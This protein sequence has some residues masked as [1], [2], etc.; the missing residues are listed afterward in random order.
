[1]KC[2]SFALAV[3][4]A[5]ATCRAMTAT[6]APY[7]R[8][9]PGSKESVTFDPQAIWLENDQL[10]LAIITCPPHAGQVFRLLYKPMNLELGNELSPQ[11]FFWDRNAGIPG[12]AFHRITSATGEIVTQSVDQVRARVTYVQSGEMDGKKIE[13]TNT[14]LYTLKQGAAFVLANWTVKN[15]GEAELAFNP[16]TKHLGRT[17]DTLLQGPCRLMLTS[18]VAEFTDFI[19]PAAN[20]TARLSG[21]E[22]SEAAPMLVSLTDYRKLF[23]QFV[24]RSPP[25]QTIETVYTR[26]NLKTGESYEVPLV[27][28]VA[29]NLSGV[30]YGA[31]ELSAS[32]EPS[33]ALKAGEAAALTVRIAASIDWGERR[34]EG[35]FA[36]EDGTIIAPVPH[37]QVMLKPG[38]I[39]AFP[40]AFTPPADG[41]Y[42]LNLTVFD[43]QPA[44]RLGLDVD[45]QRT[46]IS[47]PV[48]AGQV[49]ENA[50][51]AWQSEGAQWPTRETRDFQPWRTLHNSKSLKAGQ[52]RVPDRV[53]PEDRPVFAEKTE[54]AAIR[55][56]GGEY[57]CLQFFVETPEGTDPMTLTAS[58]SPIANA[59]GAALAP[60]VLREQIYLTTDTPSGYMTF[61]V[62]QWPDPLFETDWAAAIPEAPIAKRNVKFIQESRKRVYWLTLRAPADAKPGLYKGTVSLAL[63]GK[64]AAAFPV[65]VTVSGFALPKRAHFRCSTGLVGFRGTRPSNWEILGLPT[66]T[67]KA[68]T[69]GA[70]DAYRR[71]ILE[72]GWT[73]TMWF[74]GV[75]VWEEY[76]DVGRG[77]SVFPSGKNKENEDW[78]IANDL[79][80]YAF[81]Y[82][83]F[84]EHPDGKVPEV[85]EWAKK[86]KEESK[87]P[88]LD[89][90]YGGK[91]D[92]LFGLVDVWL[93]QDPRSAHWGEPTPPLGW[94]D[95]AVARKAAGDQFMSCNASLIWHVEYVPVTGRAQFWD[96]FAAGV[97][98]RYVYSTCRW[99]DDLYEKN[100]TTGNYMGSV[101]YPGPSG[102]TT[103]I[104]LETLRDAIEDYDYLAIL[105]D[106]VKQAAGKAAADQIAAAK[107]IVED[108]KLSE[109]V[110]TTDDLHAM[111]DRI[112]DLIEKL[113]APR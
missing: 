19:Q 65:E 52:I 89:C 77:P 58:V 50:V 44:V 56:A 26:A 21:K 20:W 9:D 64:P 33:A 84:D 53:F 46:H 37:Q 34:L 12:G 1:M 48:F 25:R 23:Q 40:V 29:A 80:Q 73:P 112:A 22:N 42:W 99:T 110:K 98:G 74:S 113:N 18:G 101:V 17:S 79:L 100:W 11:G 5:A 61:P 93:G 32:I 28:A 60:T 95:K 91:V 38:K 94:G 36:G 102:I 31:P 87:I 24:W 54:P 3:L 76:K 106:A 72:Y 78:L 107:A 97:D 2:N 45:S 30:A 109:K 4:M 10:K 51:K 71:L 75:K 16:A 88:I 49:P 7:S 15:T 66:N 86:W 8:I 92:P 90:Y 35:G 6:R 67:V 14:K 70:M 68:I 39:V 85:V 108:P 105:R 27:L 69:A 103:S 63:A 57:E 104:R 81:I 47:L 82:A 13:I 59:A 55:L 43:G 62:G 83:P 41:V 96:D 111:R